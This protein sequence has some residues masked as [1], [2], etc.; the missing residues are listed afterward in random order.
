MNPFD[1]WDEVQPA[2]FNNVKLPADGYICKILD[3]EL[4]T[5]KNGNEML[6]VHLDIAVGNF[7]NYFTNKFENRKQYNDNPKFPCIFRILT[8]GKNLPRFKKFISNIENSNSNFNFKANHFNENSLKNK[9]VGFIFREEEFSFNDK[10]GF[11]IK[12]FSSASIEDIKNKNFSIPEP[13]LLKKEVYKSL[14]DDSLDEV[15]I[16]F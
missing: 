12:P 6:F 15:D 1:N 4:R 5:S 10:H 2:N 13:K 3:I 16:P 8:R 7:K 11:T 9:F 14:G